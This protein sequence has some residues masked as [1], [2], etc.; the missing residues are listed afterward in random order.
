MLP[1]K[2]LLEQL[3]VPD[4]DVQAFTEY[5]TAVL[6]RGGGKPPSAATL[7]EWKSE[8]QAAPAEVS[9]WSF[10]QQPENAA[11]LKGKDERFIDRVVF[12]CVYGNALSSF[13]EALANAAAEAEKRVDQG[14]CRLKFSDGHFDRRHQALRAA[15]YPYRPAC[16]SGPGHVTVDCV[17]EANGEQLVGYI[18]VSADGYADDLCVLPSHSG[19]GIA[20]GL[21]CAAAARLEAAGVDEL[22]LHV[23][24]CNHPAIKLYESL[25][26]RKG[27]LEFPGWY[28]WHG[29]HHMVGKAKDIAALASAAAL[30]SSPA[31]A[32]AQPPK[33]S[34]DARRG[35][36]PDFVSLFSDERAARSASRSQSGASNCG[37]T[38]VM[39]QLGAL[40]ISEA[41]GGFVAV[42]ARDYSTPSLLK[43]L[44]SRSNAGC[45][46]ED[47]VA[48]ADSLS[49]G[50]AVARF[51]PTGPAPP[52]G[53]AAFLAD[54]VAL[55]GAPIATVNT[56][57]DGA[58]Y[59][60][61]QAILGVWPRQARVL[62]ANPCEAQPEAELARLLGSDSVMLIMEHD[63]QAHG[64]EERSLREEL[65]AMRA[66]PAWAKL[67]VA[68]QVERMKSGRGHGDGADGKLVIPA[69]YTPGITVIAPRGSKA[70]R[71]LLEESGQGPWR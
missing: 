12:S 20:R 32:S 53:L 55:G 45:T 60:H 24:A 9:V 66:E 31:P 19:C 46:A 36:L 62:L 25:G 35:D 64:R 1:S 69:S 13:K 7:K 61:H 6:S 41:P 50:R 42:R 4:S 11:L 26:L 17:D 16:G 27:D 63:V 3:K 10:L 38:A 8:L 47:L 43:Y 49:G 29:G 33:P 56:Q 51:F 15:A 71:R 28:D 14:S 21:V 65:S 22:N 5:F 40:G 23:R 59:W 44:R 2:A 70:A 52:T 67:K 39:T 57:L 34:S 30:A 68:E 37:E 48:G 18:A 54:W 58:D